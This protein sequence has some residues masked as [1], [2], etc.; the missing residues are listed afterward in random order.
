MRPLPTARALALLLLAFLP[1]SGCA[2]EPNDPAGRFG[3]PFVALDATAQNHRMGRGVNVLSNDPVWSG[4]ADA[5]FAPEDFKLIRAAGFQ[6]V[7]IV[8]YAFPHMDQNDRLDPAWLQRLDT[9]LSAAIVQ[10]LTVILDEHDDNKCAPDLDR[11]RRLLTAFWSQI[12]VRY[13]DAPNRVAFE[14]L[15]EPHGAL[16]AQSWNG[17]VREVLGVIRRSNPT[18]NLIVGTVEY[19]RARNL[20]V[21][22]LPDEDR[23]LIV[24]VHYY[25]PVRFTHQGASWMPPEIRD[26]ADIHW[27]TPEELAALAQAFEAM[28]AWSISHDRP[29][30]LGEFGAYERAPFEDRVRWTCAVARTA[31]REG[32]SW[33]YWQFDP[34]FRLYDFAHRSWVKPILKALI[35]DPPPARQDATALGQ[36][37]GC[38]IL[39][40]QAE[41]L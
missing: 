8:L 7:R 5:R 20:A 24:T 28:K 13:A 38:Q 39:A 27:G 11:C 21:L 12:A 37:S 4:G 32:I 31:E 14:I 33:A 6:T 34:D 26:G 17:L 40:A 3:E 23:H 18:R 30:F 36:I 15:N 19:D 2:A 9:M 16:T 10:G 22:D 1:G 35:P 29:L 25:D 41:R